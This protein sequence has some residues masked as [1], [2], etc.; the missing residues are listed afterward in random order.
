MTISFGLKLNSA[1]LQSC[2]LPKGAVTYQL[3]Q[4]KDT[5]TRRCCTDG[6]NTTLAAPSAVFGSFELLLNKLRTE[7][8]SW[9]GKQ[10]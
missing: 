2:M 4:L 10:F 9:S 6:I 7:S 1:I 5:A 3:N 8:S